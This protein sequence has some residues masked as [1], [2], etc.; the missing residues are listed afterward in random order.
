MVTCELQYMSSTGDTTAL[1]KQEPLSLVIGGSSNG[2]D[3][4]MVDLCCPV[5]QLL[6][7]FVEDC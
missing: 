4:C 6:P 5:I 1:D 3:P 2:T 7:R